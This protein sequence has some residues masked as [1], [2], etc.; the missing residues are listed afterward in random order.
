MEIIIKIIIVVLLLLIIYNL[1]KA[2]FSILKGDKTGNSDKPKM[3]HFIGRRLLF[4][5]GLF[6]FLLVLMALGVIQPNPNPY[7]SH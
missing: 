1:F 4:T 5:A 3:S 2:M 6:I 7:L